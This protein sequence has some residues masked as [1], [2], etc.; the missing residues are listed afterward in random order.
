M[1]LAT[2]RY[3][4]LFEVRGIARAINLSSMQIVVDGGHWMVDV[5]RHLL[6]VKPV[7]RVFHMPYSVFTALCWAVAD[8]KSATAAALDRKVAEVGFEVE[9]LNELLKQLLTDGLL[10]DSK[11]DTW[12]QVAMVILQE[13]WYNMVVASRIPPVE[14]SGGQVTPSF[15]VS[16]PGV[17]RDRSPLTDIPGSG[18]NRIR[19]LYQN[20]PKNSARQPQIRAQTSCTTRNIADSVTNKTIP[21]PHAG[22]IIIG[23]PTT[24][25][26]TPDPRRM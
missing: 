15:L 7:G 4:F 22:R 17:G 14:R 18:Q 5:A 9:F 23:R 8:W 25:V 19:I 6:K 2:E 20:E 13:K 26:C 21:Y 1:A 12:S 10:A 16:P 3:S 11:L 24:S